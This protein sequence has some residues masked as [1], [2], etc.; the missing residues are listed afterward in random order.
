MRGLLTAA[1]AEAV[2]P[3][4][5]VAQQSFAGPSEVRD[6]RPIFEGRNDALPAAK[7]DRAGKTDALLRRGEADSVEN[8]A[9]GEGKGGTSDHRVLYEAPISLH[10]PCQPDACRALCA[11]SG[12]WR[13]S[14]QLLGS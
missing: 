5:S 13:W 14:G 1:S 6:C 2:K 8:I 3:F 7:T 11:R 9:E 4:G 10:Y 12:Q